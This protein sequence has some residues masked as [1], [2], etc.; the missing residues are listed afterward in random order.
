MVTI[1][2]LMSAIIIAFILVYYKQ[3]GEFVSKYI[4]TQFGTIYEK[5]APYSFKVVRDKVK[6]L[7]QEYTPRQYTIQIVTFAVS[8]AVIS[9]GISI[10]TGPGRPVLAIA[11]ASRIV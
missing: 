6:E 5:L 10:S 4:T 2:F 3:N 1:A 8:A 9:L 7:G 11:N